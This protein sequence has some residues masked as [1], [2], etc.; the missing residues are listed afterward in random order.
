MSTELTTQSK[1]LTRARL[2]QLQ[3]YLSAQPNSLQRED[4]PP[5]QD[6]FLDGVYLRQTLVPAGNIV[7]SEIHKTTNFCILA[8]GVAHISKGDKPAE[9]IVGPQ[10]MITY[11]GERRVLYAE[12]DAT[13]M[14]VHLTDSKDTKEI[15]EEV[16]AESYDDP[17]ILAYETL[18]LENS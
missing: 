10:V 7:L 1:E 11:P 9:R 18:Q 15:E 12:T 3:D 14:N 2:G 6:H 17:A 5:V 13:F 4:F 16:I 8:S